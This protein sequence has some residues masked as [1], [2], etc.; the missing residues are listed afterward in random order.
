MN[1]KMVARGQK[2]K[3]HVEDDSGGVSAWDNQLQFVLDISME[4]FN[5]DQAQV[6]PCLLRSVLINNT[7]RQVQSEVRAQVHSISNVKNPTSQISA[8]SE[9]GFPQKPTVVDHTAKWEAENAENDFMGWMSD[10]DFSLSSAISGIL[11]DLDAVIDGS[12]ASHWAPLGSI[13]NLTLTGVSLCPLTNL[14]S[15]K[16]ISTPLSCSKTKATCPCPQDLTLDKLLDIDASLFEP[17]V[18][19]QND[20]QAKCR[21]STLSNSPSASSSAFVPPVQTPALWEFQDLEHVMDFLMQTFP[22]C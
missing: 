8:L 9:L 19:L 16:L 10:D 22:P 2:R 20:D 21:L 18:N 1:L 15:E 6:E 12:C 14:R 5:K 11:K 17:E 13:D 4:K 3:L 7:L